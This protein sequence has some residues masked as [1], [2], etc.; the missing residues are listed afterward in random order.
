MADQLAL[1]LPWRAAMGRADFFLSPCN[2][3]ALAGVEAWRD[4]PM[5]KMILIGPEGAG[6]THLT[7]VFAAQSGARVIAAGA[8]DLRLAAGL[9]DADAVAVEDCDTIAG[10]AAREEALFHLHN[11]LAA[12]QAP[13]LISGRER[14]ETWGIAL[15][16]LASRLSQAGLLRLLPPDDA[17]L[18]AVMMKL[19]QDRG[20][21]LPPAVIH[22]ALPRLERSFAA[23]RGFVEALDHTA[24]AQGQAPALRHARHI[25]AQSL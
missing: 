24:L 3:A 10:D 8:L 15:P 25:L 20:L 13:L 9:T 21:A 16:D 4:W 1:D 11:D 23:A 22:Y 14:P 12:R 19:G 2:A 6:K 7:H 18:M 5:C 17:A